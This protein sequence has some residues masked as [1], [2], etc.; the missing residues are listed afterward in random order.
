MSHRTTHAQAVEQWRKRVATADSP[1]RIVAIFEH[2]FR[3]LWSRA[4]RTLGDVTMTAIVDRV[5]SVAAEHTPLL[6]GVHVDLQGVHCDGLLSEAE[7]LPPEETLQALSAV[8]TDFLTVLGNLTAEILTPAMHASLASVR[9]DEVETARDRDGAGPVD[10]S[11]EG[12]DK[13]ER[14]K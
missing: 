6:A 11:A 10:D 3:T 13:D 12:A 14:A 4:Q 7:Q 2:T 5:L 1:E 9:L 8:L